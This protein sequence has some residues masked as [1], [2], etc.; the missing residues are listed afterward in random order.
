MPLSVEREDNVQLAKLGR[1]SFL[2]SLKGIMYLIEV[3]P[4]LY[5]TLEIWYL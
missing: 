3:S 1:V 2:F 5:K 4:Q